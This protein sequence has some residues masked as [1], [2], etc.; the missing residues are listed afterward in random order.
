MTVPTTWDEFK[1]TAQALKDAGETPIVLGGK[2]RVHTFFMYIG[3]ASSVL[4]LDGL[5]QLRTGARS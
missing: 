4:G 5:Q 2:D 1:A 3:L